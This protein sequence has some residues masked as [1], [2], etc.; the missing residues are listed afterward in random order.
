MKKVIEADMNRLIQVIDNLL[1]NDIK[2]TKEACY[3]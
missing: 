2:F 3:C 1:H